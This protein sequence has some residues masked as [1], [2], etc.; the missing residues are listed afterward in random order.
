MPR[1]AKARDVIMARKWIEQIF[2]WDPLRD[3]E[4]WTV[5]VEDVTRCTEPRGMLVK[6]RFLDAPHL[7]RVEDI[8]LDLP[9]RPVGSTVEFVR[10]A[11]LETPDGAFVPRDAI[12]RTV[13]ARFAPAPDGKSWVA[14]GFEPVASGTGPAGPA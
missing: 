3:G 1:C 7:G 12:S 14:V 9:A 11:G 5:A 6:L 8:F 10:S 2:G 13:R 4:W